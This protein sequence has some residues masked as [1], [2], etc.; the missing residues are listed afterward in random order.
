[1]KWLEKYADYAYALLRIVA[2]FMLAFHGSQKILGFLSEFR[3]P[4]GSQLW[5]GGIIELV[6]GLLIMLGLLT[7][8]AAF[9]CSGMMAVA[10]IQ[11]HWK[12]QLG[13]Q[14]FP[15]INKGELAIMFCLAFLYIAC[16]GGVKWS[17][18]KKD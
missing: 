9:I 5:I 13:A 15:A 2:G 11:Y 6:G 14:I 3:P 17:I 10:Y 16:R 18:D 7:R 12:F 1:M 8:G 4:V